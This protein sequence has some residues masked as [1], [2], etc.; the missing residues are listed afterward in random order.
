MSEQRR[1]Y[2]GTQC[3]QVCHVIEDLKGRAQLFS[4]SDWQRGDL[5]GVI[6]YAQGLSHYTVL[7]TL[8]GTQC[9][10]GFQGAA[11]CSFEESA[12]HSL[13]GGELV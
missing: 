13:L 5:K 4:G 1:Y 11:P 6:S 7:G 12:W 8:H 2:P 3:T 10:S 9:G